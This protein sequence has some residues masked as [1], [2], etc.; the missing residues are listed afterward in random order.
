MQTVEHQTPFTIRPDAPAPVEMIT[1]AAAALLLGCG[2]RHAR[3]LAKKHD[4]L[5]TNRST[6]GGARVMI[7]RADVAAYLVIERNAAQT[8]PTPTTDSELC[9]AAARRLQILGPVMAAADGR[10][11]AIIKE[12]AATFNISERSIRR[13]IAGLK[14]AQGDAAVLDDGR[15]G[16]RNAA[17]YDWE[18]IK[19]SIF[20]VY[21][22]RIAPTI[23]QAF[24]GY[25]QLRREEPGRNLPEIPQRTFA[26]YVR[27]FA[28]AL[29]ARRRGGDPA[30]AVRKNFTR[31]VYRDWTD[32]RCMGVW[33]GDGTAWDQL[34]YWTGYQ[35]P[36]RP[37]FLTWMDIRTRRIV[38]WRL[39]DKVNG[40]TAM[41]ALRDGWRTWGLCDELYVDNGKEYENKD[42]RGQTVYKG[43]VA[44]GHL[45]G[46][47]DSIGVH[48]RNAIVRN[49]ESKA[50]MER[51]YATLSG[52]YLSLFD[53]HTGGNI[54]SLTRKKDDARLKQDLKAGRVFNQ[55]QARELAERVVAAYNAAPHS[56]LG[57]KSPDQMWI[58]LYGKTADGERF[59]DVTKV[60]DTE[61]HFA[62]MRRKQKTI[63]AG[64]IEFYKKMYGP[65]DRNDRKFMDAKGRKG[66]FSYDPEDVTRLHLYAFG[67]DQR[68][69]YVCDLAP[70]E[71]INAADEHEL[72]REFRAKQAE[73][74]L[75]ATAA[76]AM[77]D[78]TIDTKGVLQRGRLHISDEAKLRQDEIAAMGTDKP[79]VTRFPAGQTADLAKGIPEKTEGQ[80]EVYA[81][82]EDRETAAKLAKYGGMFGEKQKNRG[83]TCK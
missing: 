69:Q 55:D 28:P 1:S 7:S 27:K 40:A 62:L 8:I 5:T 70:I 21:S 43:K 20:S 34:V 72:R 23:E 71:P 74:K 24:L 4:W 17:K 36:I 61:L 77:L 37:W 52:S 56:S 83:E 50:Q 64:G 19:F 32:V 16:N 82:E 6:K 60:S 35:K 46:Y 44:I 59:Q 42:S 54:T 30:R 18:T 10:Q 63:R 13:W 79:N 57:K 68:P 80:T 2:D 49:P 12:Q 33:M 15:K 75:M 58:D 76:K 39:V 41:L 11:T 22:N 31:P 81:D 66:F 14:N 25:Q 9:A 51:W 45:D 26:Y 48:Q 65:A 38:A 53:A 3:R 78:R 29:L 67:P 73:E 47:L